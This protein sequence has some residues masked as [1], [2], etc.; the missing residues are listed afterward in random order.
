MIT[1][2]VGDNEYFV[3]DGLNGYIV[4]V[5]DNA[6]MAKAIVDAVQRK[7]WNPIEISE[8]LAVGDWDAVAADVINFFSTIANPK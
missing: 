6:A 1:T 2:P 3:K 4:P 7:D 8:N 5:D